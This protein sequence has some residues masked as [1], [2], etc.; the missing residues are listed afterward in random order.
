MKDLEDI[1]YRLEKLSSERR[2]IGNCQAEYDRLFELKKNALLLEKGETAQKILEVM[3]KIG[4]L[5]SRVNEVN[6]ALNVGSQVIHSLD[7][8]MGCLDSAAGWGTFDLLGG[9]FI[10][11][12]AKHS[13]IDE[14]RSQIEET[15]RLLRSFRT[16]LADVEIS[17]DLGIGTGGFATFADFFFDGL[18]ADWY[19]QSR[20][21]QS[22]ASADSVR[23]QVSSVIGRLENMNDADKS[24][25]DILER[26]LSDLVVNSRGV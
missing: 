11:D 16:E 26:A 6:E 9:G 10:D 18:I 25:L 8:A 3:E 13:H 17:A 5:K 14:A 2:D 23:E 4:F 15:Q 7:A 1:S 12:M 21:K 19:M 22:L 24:E 20:I